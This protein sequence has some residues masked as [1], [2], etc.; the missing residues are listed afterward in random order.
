M[1]RPFY[2]IAHRCNNFDIAQERLSQGANA[3]EIDVNLWDGEKVINKLY[4]GHGPLLVPGSIS[5]SDDERME[6]ESYFQLLQHAA[7]K[8][9]LIYLDC[10]PPVHELGKDIYDLAKK[11]LS[12]TLIVFSYPYFDKD[13]KCFLSTVAGQIITNSDS[14]MVVQFD[15]DE[16]WGA[17]LAWFRENLISNFGYS[18]GR[19][20]GI[21][22]LFNEIWNHALLDRVQGACCQRL[23]DKAFKFCGAWTIDSPLLMKELINIGVDGMLTNDVPELVTVVEKEAAKL[24]SLIYK[25]ITNGSASFYQPEGYGLLLKTGKAWFAG[26]DNS[27]T[28]TLKAFSGD[29]TSATIIGDPPGYDRR[30]D[31][32]SYDYWALSSAKLG[33]L[34][35]ITIRLDPGNFD[36]PDWYLESVSVWPYTNILNSSPLQNWVVQ[37]WI[38]PGES[39]VLTF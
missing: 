19:T 21:A 18:F 34:Q 23:I 16:N 37:N 27:I 1:P 32:G 26:T 6:L 13:G 2:I 28:V 17:Q 8:P 15:M 22:L 39:V 3:I 5:K 9:L 12:D 25:A 33:N 4:A 10:K 24:N 29:Q 31:R 35:S 36:A 11:Y 38:K 14:H 20:F 30:F 7:L